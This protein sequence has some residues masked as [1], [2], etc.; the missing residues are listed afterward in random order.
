MKTEE[1]RKRLK[2]KQSNYMAGFQMVLSFRQIKISDV[3][4]AFEAGVEETLALIEG[5][6]L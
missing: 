2:E 6:T 5:R 4:D 3:K 1:A